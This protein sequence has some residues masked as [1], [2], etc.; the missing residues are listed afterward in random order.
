[1]LC[2]LN[3]DQQASIAGGGLWIVDPRDPSKNVAR[4]TFAFKQAQ[5][6]FKLC[7]DK[8][9][10]AAATASLNGTESSSVD[11]SKLLIRY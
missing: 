10:S 1:M 5:Q 3:P 4:P 2:D 8:I 11:F 9:E 7:L 6:Y